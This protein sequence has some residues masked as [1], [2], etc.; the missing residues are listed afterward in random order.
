M[1]YKEIKRIGNTSLYENTDVLPFM[2]VS[3]NYYNKKKS[4]SK[5]RINRFRL[6]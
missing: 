3:Y 1:H 2:Y 4:Q 6:N 5:K